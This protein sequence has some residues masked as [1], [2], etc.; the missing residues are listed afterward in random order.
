MDIVIIAHFVTEFVKDGTSRFVYIA[1]QLSQSHNVELITSRFDHTKK[2]QRENLIFDLKTKVTLME[3]TSYKKNVSVKRFL[4]HKRFGRKVEE[5]LENRKKPD[6]IYCAVPSLD[7]AYYA[8]KYAQKNNVKFVI[9]VQ[10]LW[11]EA[12]KMVLNI[13]G[14]SDIL[15]F[16]MQKKAEF[17]YSVADKIVGVSETYCDIAG[18]V[19]KKNAE[20]VPVF[21][22]TKLECFDKYVSQNM[23]FRNDDK[24]II[25][26]CGTLGHS[27][28][29][30]CVLDAMILLRDKG[31]Q[32]ISFW[33]MGDG[34]RKEEFEQYALK[35]NLEVIFWGRLAYEK[36]CGL[37]VACDICVNPIVG[38][39]VA[40]IINKHGDYAA[41]GI[42][43]INTQTSEEYQNLIEKYECGINCRPSNAIE[44][45][46]AIVFFM[47]NPEERINMGKQARKLA[48]EKFDRETTYSRIIEIIS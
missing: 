44:V 17:I 20:Q 30:K 38:T 21:L 32:N 46:E 1:E 40:S 4:S 7:C 23:Y 42:P 39:S 9:D 3:E 24:F 41:S 26:Y 29:I 48:E 25:G 45:M 47:N 5:Y 33:I 27:Y 43:V 37:L 18:A 31:Y 15:F 14:L 13:P 12:F 36:M 22:G 35:H 16:P 8:A 19:N 10:D 28:D 11:P 2:Q 6:V 34:P